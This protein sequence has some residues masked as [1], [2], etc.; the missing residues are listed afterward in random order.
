[1]NEFNENLNESTEVEIEETVS[2]QGSIFDAPAEHKDKKKK[3]FK[4]QIIAVVSSAL[5]LAILLTGV[6][7]YDAE[8][9]KIF[10]LKI[11]P[12]QK[13]TVSTPKE[14]EPEIEAVS[15]DSKK[16]SHVTVT[17][18]S[19]AFN[20][21]WKLDT[22]AAEADTRIWCVEGLDSSVTSSAAIGYVAANA[23][24]IYA[25][26]IIEGRNEAD[27]G[28]NKPQAKIDVVLSDGEG[29]YTVTIG[30]ASADKTGTY[31]KVSGDDKIYLVS[32]EYAEYFDFSLI[33]LADTSDLAAVGYDSSIATYFDDSKILKTF[34][35]ITVSGE[36]YDRNIVIVPNPVA[37]QKDL[38]PF[39]ISSPY[40][41][42]A[43]N[44]DKLVTMFTSGVDIMGAYSYDISAASLKKYGLDKP[45]AVVTAKIGPITKTY[46][47]SVVDDEY[48]AIIDENKKMIKTV[49]TSSVP[50]V[51]YEES[52]FYS[53]W[54]CME[55]L[56]Q[57]SSYSAKIGDNEYKFGISYDDTQ[58]ENTDKFTV[59]RDTGKIISTA[60]FQTFYQYFLGLKIS[61]FK[62]Q[63]ISASASPDAVITFIYS[64]D[65]SKKVY[66]FYKVSDSKYQY[67]I[68][69]E[70]QG[71]ITTTSYNKMIKN[72]KLI[73]ENKDIVP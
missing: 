20:L 9:G 67:S 19:G 49:A 15:V 7:T 62:T 14:E 25:S 51:E 47:I 55:M 3:D 33:D 27:C 64:A 52:K 56:N 6:F 38:V 1:M 73:A 24:S 22:Q 21:Y 69:G 59:V 26:R 30:S 32:N 13:N 2:E 42:Y 37:D 58:T 63:E 17:N 10:W 34:D 4:T 53:N 60:N 46:K 11:L 16:I 28:F 44:I 35:K 18:K 12:K 72:I 23:G 57:L 43:G 70:M 5:V 45:D 68:N 61:D 41:R 29:E 8:N 40:N 31:L 48:C 39:L 36:A 71:K 65:A 66:A 54:L 50:F